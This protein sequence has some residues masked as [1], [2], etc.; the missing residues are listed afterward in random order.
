MLGVCTPPGACI[1]GVSWRGSHL[2]D[3]ILVPMIYLVVE[4]TLQLAPRSHVVLLYRREA[5]EGQDGN[6]IDDRLHHPEQ[7]ACL[8]EPQVL[9]L[10]QSSLIGK[11]G[12]Q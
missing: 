10:L 3:I 12:C 1:W 8:S 11:P 9:T 2:L 4:A 5:A 6:E 7:S